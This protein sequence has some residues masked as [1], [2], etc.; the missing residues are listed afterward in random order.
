MNL[1]TAHLVL[2]SV[3][4]AALIGSAVP[5]AIGRDGQ[6]RE[7][8]PIAQHADTLGAERAEVPTDEEDEENAILEHA[9]EPWTGDFDGMVER[10][11]VRVLT[12]HNPL[13]FTYD[14]VERRGL[15]LEVARAFERHLAKV[16]RKKARA[17]HVVIIP[18]AR[19]ELLPCLLD[20][21]GDIVAANLTI[22]PARRKLVAFSDPTYPNVRELV[23]SGPAAPP[24]R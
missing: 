24:G 1:R 9:L 12:V 16:T 11:F 20:G 19:D 13:F 23:I 8:R 7:A 18:V 17:P 2:S 3:L 14:G 6:T 10:G 4:V 22:T 15:V 5:Q 21:K